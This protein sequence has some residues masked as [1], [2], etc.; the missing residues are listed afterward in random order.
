MLSLD[1]RKPIGR[2]AIASELPSPKRWLLGL[3]M[4]RMTQ[5][6]LLLAV[7]LT[8]L[9]SLN[10]DTAG[11]R[12][13]DVKP[14]VDVEKLSN[15]AAIKSVFAK[16]AS[17][18]SAINELMVRINEV[19]A[20]PFQEAA[21]AS[22][23]AE[24]F[25]QLG[26]KVTLDDVGNVIAELPGKP[27]QKVIAVVAHLDT[28]FPP[29]TPVAVFRD[30]DTFYA[31]GIG[32]NSRGVAMMYALASALLD[33]ELALEHTVLFIASVGE[34]GLGDLRGMRRLFSADAKRPIDEVIV[35]D[36][37][38]PE[39][40]V[41]VAVG[42]K[43]YRVTIKGPGGHSYGN[44]GMVHPHQALAAAIVNLTTEADKLVTDAT[45]RATYSVG[46]IGGGTSINSIPFE[47]WMEVD[48][49]SPD[50]TLLGALDDVLHASVRQAV[51]SE[52]LRGDANHELSYEM[53]AVG[54]RPAGRML[55]NTPIVERA[56]AALQAV[57]LSAELGASSTDANIPISKGIPAVT[58][59][60]GGMSKNAHSLSE[61]WQDI[62]TLQSEQAAMLLLLMTAG[63]VNDD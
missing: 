35:I 30:G 33:G 16:L 27:G 24:E 7:L 42:S 15:S 44:F 49:R 55:S 19:A 20:P 28:V 3:E 41:N 48:L 17:Q 29:E 4:R 63:Y 58:I 52:N 47:S 14:L 61:S 32:D 11:A 21:R 43:R 45:A 50:E 31:P 9:G 60:R 6:G 54:D 22:M 13:W 38:K 8:S 34:E 25:R 57:G 39:R 12:H 5:K 37:G 56:K 18:H 36:G 23:V 53:L 46:R 2:V 59:S 10:S 26:L 51:L 1:Q 40:I 62:N